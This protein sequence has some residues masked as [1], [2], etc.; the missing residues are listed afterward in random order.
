MGPDPD[1]GHPERD[2][3]RVL[4]YRFRALRPVGLPHLEAQ[5]EDGQGDRWEEDGGP[6]RPEIERDGGGLVSA[7]AAAGLRHL[8]ELRGPLACGLHGRQRR[9]DAWQGGRVR[10]EGGGCG[11]WRQEEVSENGQDVFSSDTFERL[12]SEQVAAASSCTV[13][14][15][16]G[17]RG[18]SFERNDFRVVQPL[19]RHLLLQDL[20]N[21]TA[22]DV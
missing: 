12:A 1:L 11:S 7:S 5:V 22:L 14:P 9:G 20:A 4:A 3:G 8:Q 21:L 17:G 18:T 19:W 16:P 6:A 10:E 15:P 2:Q 13:R